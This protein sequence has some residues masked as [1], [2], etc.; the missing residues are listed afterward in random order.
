MIPEL[1]QR[2]ILEANTP[3]DIN[4][5]LPLM[6]ILAKLC[7]HITE[8]G[9]RWGNSATVWFNNPVV[10]RGY[11]I[12]EFPE[13]TEIFTLARS[14]GRDC[15]LI[16]ADTGSLQSI[17]QTD[18]L[19]IDSLHTYE[20]VKKELKLAKFVNKFIVLHDTELFGQ[21]GEDGSTPGLL[22]AIGEF[23]QEDGEW[24]VMEHR[25]FNNG[26]TVLTRK[27]LL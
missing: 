3:S 25:T 23:L 2:F 26:L 7:T 12:V 13:A 22:Q 19:F 1:Q 10:F 24:T 8:F 27:A 9:V 17:E 4:Q 21:S 16:I 15:A 20:H 14:L 11:D 6:N 5:H 18:L